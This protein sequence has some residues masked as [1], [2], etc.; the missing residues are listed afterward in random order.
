MKRINW[1]HANRIAA[2]C[3]LAAVPVVARHSAPGASPASARTPASTRAQAAQPVRSARAERP[4]QAWLGFG[5]A[6]G[7]CELMTRNGVSTWS[8]R[9]PPVVAEVTPGSPAARAGLRAGDTLIALDGVSLVAEAGGMRLSRLEPGQKLTLAYRRGYEG[10]A[11]LVSARQPESDAPQEPRGA[12]FTGTVAG[13]DIE[14]WGPGRTRV[15]LHK[16]TGVLEISMQDV[17]VRI[18]PS[19]PKDKR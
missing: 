11:R 17:T 4:A 13:A 18:R 1:T 3:C 5:I 2:V 7:D 6:C 16:A 9:K 15:T 10:S 19:A 14:V 12:G 8:F